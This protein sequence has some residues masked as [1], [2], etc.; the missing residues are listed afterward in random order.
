MGSTKNRDGKTK[1]DATTEILDLPQGKITVSRKGSGQQLLLLHGGGGPVINHPFA[2]VLAQNF[3]LISPI[4]P[5]YNG[6]PVPDHFDWM[7]D[8]VHFYLDVLDALK[9]DKA[10]VMGFS[11]GGWL[12]AELASMSCAKFSRLILVD[13]VGV[14]HGGPTDRDIADVFGMAAPALAAIMWH[15]PSK[16]PDLGTLT[17]EQL[18]MVASNRAALGLYTWE[19]FMHNPKL[20]H[21]LHRINIPTKLIWGASDGL[22]TPEYGEKYAKL[23]PGAE[24]VTIPEAGHS[25]Q[26]E[27]PEK[28]VAEVMRFIGEGAA[29]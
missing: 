27:Q 9:I 3:E 8:L 12:A 26:G 10:V 15:D 24:F 5:G 28:F 2:D 4:H 13:A 1:M 29:A 21:W 22:V 25:P 17:D 19:P 16:A 23:I 14:K 18:E 11:M 7:S 20:P 6:T